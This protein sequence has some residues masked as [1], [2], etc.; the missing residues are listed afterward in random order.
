MNSLHR[1][2]GIGAGYKNVEQTFQSPLHIAYTSPSNA[3]FRR[4]ILPLVAL[5]D[6]LPFRSAFHLPF[7]GWRPIRHCG[8]TETD[9]EQ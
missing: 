6:I 8:H 9:V 7:A 5:P 2:Y 1:I 3:A 4:C